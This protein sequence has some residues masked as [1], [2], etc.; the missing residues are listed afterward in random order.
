[1][2]SYSHSQIDKVYN[3]ILDQEEHHKTKTF[4]E[5]YLEFLNEFQVEFKP[6]YLFD[7]ID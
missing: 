4:K 1:V 5:E 7:W 2:F 6:Q 3:Y